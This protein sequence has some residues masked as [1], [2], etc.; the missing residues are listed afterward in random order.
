MSSNLL[1][2]DGLTVRTERQPNG[3]FTAIDDSTYSGPGSPIGW[4]GSKWEA[5]IDLLDQMGDCGLLSEK[6]M[7]RSPHGAS[8]C[9]PISASPR[10]DYAC[11]DDGFAARSAAP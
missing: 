9:E 8:R 7:P 4:G 1:H 10:G 2:F 6:L 11:A 5:V 3:T